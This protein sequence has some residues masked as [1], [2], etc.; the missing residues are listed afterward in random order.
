MWHDLM[1]ATALMF[2]IEGIVPFM[3]P[4]HMRRV[5]YIIADL[6]DRALRTGGLATMLI[7]VVMLYLF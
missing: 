7:G 6:D 3:S 5:L 1:A 4:T 2:V